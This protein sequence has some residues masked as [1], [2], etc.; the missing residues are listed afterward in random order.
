[1]QSKVNRN[2]R[3]NFR[4]VTWF[5]V[6]AS[7]NWIL[8]AA[9]PDYRAVEASV[10]FTSPLRPAN[11]NPKTEC[12]AEAAQK[13]FRQGLSSNLHFRQFNGSKI[14]NVDKWGC[15]I[16]RF[17]FELAARNWFQSRQGIGSSHILLFAGPHRI[18]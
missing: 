10:N 6:V 18:C 9:L 8:R 12:A 14:R 3:R 13:H 2:S 17:C 4:F 7:G 16:A 5:I 15:Q 1:V 11:N